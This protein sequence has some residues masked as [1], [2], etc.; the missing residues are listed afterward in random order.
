M[1]V[2]ISLIFLAL[3]SALSVSAEGKMNQ[4]FFRGGMGDGRVV[5]T[6]GSELGYTTAATE[7]YR[8]LLNRQNISSAPYELY[9]GFPVGI[10]KR[11][12]LG[13]FEYRL[14]N[15]LR[16]MYDYRTL[17]EVKYDSTTYA[18]GSTTQ[19]SSQNFK[20]KEE[21]KRT[22][23][24]YYHPIFSFLHV[25][26]ILRNHIMEWRYDSTA[27]TSLNISGV[28]MV[29]TWKESSI[30][31]VSGNTPGV[32]IEISPF[33]FLEFGGTYEIVNLK[34][35]RNLNYQE[36]YP[37]T[38]LGI[39]QLTLGQQNGT[40]HVNGSIINVYATLRFLSFIGIRIGHTEERLSRSYDS[41]PY[42]F[43]RYTA[44][45]SVGASSSSDAISAIASSLAF[46]NVDHAYRMQ[47]K[48][49]QLEFSMGF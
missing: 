30:T 9:S 35:T 41:F 43:Y 8:G 28:N 24:A 42:M 31:K 29:G 23:I 12:L 10:H 45:G 46:S 7:V 44:I 17:P 34:G 19:L 5:P 1:N 15:R 39:S 13:G 26:G 20:W 21:T 32:G 3:F 38:T 22:A 11:P 47:Y 25:G 18:G 36:L 37:P 27:N 4:F 6:E 14:D 16:I 48:Y 40:V 49:V 33:D 2:R